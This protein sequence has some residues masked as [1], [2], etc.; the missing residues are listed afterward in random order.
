[1]KGL[2]NTKKRRQNIQNH[3]QCLRLRTRVGIYVTCEEHGKELVKDLA[4]LHGLMGMKI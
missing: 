4:R 1:M 3:R 2:K